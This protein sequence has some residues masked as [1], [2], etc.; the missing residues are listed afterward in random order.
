YFLCSH[1]CNKLFSHYKDV[2]CECGKPMDSEMSLLVGKLKSSSFSDDGVFCKGLSRYIVSDDLEVMPPL[3][4]PVFSF[5]TKV[6]VMDAT[7]TE[8][9]TFNVGVDE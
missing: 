6:G 2:L 9:M 1:D 3:S 4:S 8:E 7:T 5:L